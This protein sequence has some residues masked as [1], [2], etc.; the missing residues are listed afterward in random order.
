MTCCNCSRCDDGLGLVLK[1]VSFLLLGSDLV[2]CQ[3]VVKDC[4]LSDGLF[5]S[6]NS[7]LGLDDL[8]TKT[9]KPISMA[10]AG[11]G[12]VSRPAGIQ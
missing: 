10:F 12:K 8:L 9:L 7:F 5:S 3:N 6:G 4:F 11:I 2:V 1:M